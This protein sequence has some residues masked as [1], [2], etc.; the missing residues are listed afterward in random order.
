ADG[1]TAVIR[2]RGWGAPRPWQLLALCLLCPP[3]LWA[4]GGDPGLPN[5]LL[6]VAAML[7]AGKLLG[8]GAERLGLPAV[9]GELT[10]G[11]LLGASVL[12]VIPATGAP[13]AEMIQ[14]LAELGVI[15][16]LFEVGLET[17]LKQLL[18][19]GPAALSVAA[20]GVVVPFALGYF[21]WA[22]LPHPATAD[23]GTIGTVAIF[24]GATLTATSVGITARV[25]GD[26]GKMETTE[27]RI[28]LGAAVVDDVI[29]L[30]ILS[31]VAGIAAGGTVTIVSV[32]TTFAVAIG[33]LVA[34]VVLGKLLVQRVAERVIRMR[35]RG[36]V[37][38]VSIAFALALAALAALVGSARIIGA[39][40]AGLILRG[41]KN[42]ATVEHEVQ[43]VAAVLAPI[44]FVNVGAAADV[45]LLD[46]SRPGAG[47]VLLI[48]GCLTLIAIAGKLV[49]GW[50]APWARFHRLTVGAGMVPRGEVGLIFADV[51]RRAGL[52][53][54][55]TFGIVLLMVMGT[56]FIGPVA[57]KL[58][59]SR[60]RS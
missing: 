52:L 9:L 37:V 33:F 39:F 57:L 16:L 25:L 49:A 41:A 45:S 1:R 4:T 18:K 31:V 7:V 55:A 48:A 12:H 6:T 32:G 22:W 24:V 59:F 44:F 54:E 36:V 50:G 29:G 15:L 21:Y 14:L 53:S 34:S 60:V 2:R 3:A 58:I 30:V 5:L 19:V 43:P 17:D 38:A 11:V 20:V 40:A 27:A 28:I 51:G 35:V 47:A 46:P 8:E 10:A 56:T 26:L 42:A 13:G 23:G